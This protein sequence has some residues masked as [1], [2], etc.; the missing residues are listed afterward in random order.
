[1]AK[2]LKCIMSCRTSTAGNVTENVS[3]TLSIVHIVLEHFTPLVP[4][5]IKTIFQLVPEVLGLVQFV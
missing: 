1:M 5:S 2:V 4:S 3:K